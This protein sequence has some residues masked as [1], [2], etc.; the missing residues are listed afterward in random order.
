M[1]DAGDYHVD[2]LLDLRTLV[3]VQGPKEAVQRADSV[4]LFTGDV[5]LKWRQ[6]EAFGYSIVSI[7]HWVWE[8]LDSLEAQME[9]LKGL[10]LLPTGA[11]ASPVRLPGPPPDESE[12]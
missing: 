10:G 3:E 1:A 8:C 12:E 7:P 5:L 11:R 4:P 9:F 2:M 6:L